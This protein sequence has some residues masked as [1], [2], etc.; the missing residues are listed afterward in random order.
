MSGTST[1]LTP[2]RSNSI[3][4]KPKEPIV[5][6]IILPEPHQCKKP[7]FLIRLVRGLRR[8]AF[9]W[10]CECGDVFKW[11]KAPYESWKWR[12]VNERDWISNGGGKKDNVQSNL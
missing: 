9:L 8:R 10:R 2:Y 7:G 3:E 12:E 6:Y 5:G 1:S 11:S 4:K